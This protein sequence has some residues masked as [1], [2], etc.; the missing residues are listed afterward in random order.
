ME[1]PKLDTTDRTRHS[2]KEDC[3]DLIAFLNTDFV[4]FWTDA[5]SGQDGIAG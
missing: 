4:T 3:D 2:F 5:D 1:T